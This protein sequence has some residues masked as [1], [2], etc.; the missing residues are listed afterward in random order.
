M[1]IVLLRDSKLREEN[2]SKHGIFGT[3][4]NPMPMLYRWAS[5]DQLPMPRSNCSNCPSGSKD[6]LAVVD[7]DAMAA[8]GNNVSRGT[9]LAI[10]KA[11]LPTYKKLEK[12]KKLSWQSWSMH[13]FS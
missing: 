13:Q 11:E 3:R 8:H 9:W 10:L 12:W 6:S 4:W 5:W 1:S 7:A 2:K